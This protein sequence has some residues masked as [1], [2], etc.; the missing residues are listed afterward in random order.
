MSKSISILHVSYAKTWRGGEQQIVHLV[1]GLNELDADLAQHV[2]CTSDSKMEAYCE[3]ASISYTSA[4]KQASLSISYIKQLIKAFKSV[5]PSIIH[6]HDSH[7]HSMLVVAHR[8]INSKIPIVLHRRV[9]FEIGK[10]VLSLKKYNYSY[11]KQ[12]ISVSD[13]IKSIIQD[14]VKAEVTTIY[15]STDIKQAHEKGKLRQEL[16]LDTDIKIIGTVAA[17]ADHKDLPTFIKTADALLKDGKKY[18]FVIIG[19]GDLRVEIE[20]MI[21]ALGIQK[22]FSLLGF[23]ADVSA[24]VKDFDVFLFTSKMEGLGS[25]IIMA[26]AMGI[27]LVCTNAGG[28]KEIVIHKETG[29]VAPVGDKNKL[30]EHVQLIIKDPF[31]ANQLLLKAKQQAENFSY[32]SMAEKTLQ[33]YKGLFL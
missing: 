3:T 27:P 24:L 14:K 4:L 5:Q 21:T 32:L 29:L 11:I 8:L 10:S 30:K 13:A 17:F 33:V 15:S 26:Q 7:A 9:D 16:E 18:H 23:R 6:V 20:S 2:F 22:Y 28:I 12:I 19:D 1:K 31:L 25:S